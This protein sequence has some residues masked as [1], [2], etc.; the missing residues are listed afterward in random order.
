[1]IM[2]K[3]LVST[4][5]GVLLMPLLFIVLFTLIGGEESGSGG[6]P[7][8]IP[9][10]SQQIF[11]DAVAPIAQE[12]YKKYGVLPSITLA[13]AVLESAWGQSGLTIQANN[14]FGIKA[15]PSWTGRVLEMET[16]EH[17]DGGIITIIARWRVYEKWE[18]SV[19]DH[20]MFLKEN[21]RYA[22]AGFF[23]AK[24]YIGQ[25]ESLV[26]AGYATNP[27][28]AKLLCSLIESYGF[29]KYDQTGG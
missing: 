29:N 1:M 25:A 23:E 12:T 18:D 27:S 4:V 24:D 2:K 5:L 14:L 28:Y 13:Q 8:I 17:V 6:N 20:G 22:A 10:E 9:N 3:L 15:D 11:I 19:T 21:S 16:Q 26:K 7:N